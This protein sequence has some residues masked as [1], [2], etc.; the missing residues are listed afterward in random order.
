MALQELL[1][2]GQE[3]R[4]TI[5]QA[6]PSDDSYSTDELLRLVDGLA[7]KTESIISKVDLD[8]TMN[9]SSLLGLQA[10]V[11]ELTSGVTSSSP[12]NEIDTVA[13]VNAQI[14]RLEY[15]MRKLKMSGKSGEFSR[16][17]DMKAAEDL[18]ADVTKMLANDNIDMIGF[19][20]Q[21]RFVK[22]M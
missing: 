19:L 16:I 18:V 15:A 6:G 2:H 14:N 20:K 7:D 17:R 8:E 22:M 3:Q 9:G 4:N 12:Q 1:G 11:N 13:T 5:G 21:D 10:R